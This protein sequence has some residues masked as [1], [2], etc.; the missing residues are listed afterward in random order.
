MRLDD[1]GTR[2]PRNA[3]PA[4]MI[5]SGRVSA[6]RAKHHADRLRIRVPARSASI[7]TTSR[8]APATVSTSNNRVS[9]P[10]VDHTATLRVTPSSS[11]GTRAIHANR[12]GM[13]RAAN[14]A[15]SAQRTT[16]RTSDSG[17]ATRSGATPAREKP[18]STRVHRKFV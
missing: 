2:L 3:D 13:R 15:T 16:V 12:G 7:S 9:S 1:A 6:A 14:Q 5:P 11:G 17:V 18:A 4:I 10:L 8:I